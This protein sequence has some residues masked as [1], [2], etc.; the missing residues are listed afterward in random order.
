M[1]KILIIIISFNLFIFSLLLNADNN[2]LDSLLSG[3][4]KAFKENRIEEGLISLDTASQIAESQKNIKACL[5]IG[6]LYKDLPAELER[7][8]F[9][10]DILK[11]GYRFAAEQKKWH[12]LGKFAEAL[13]EL[14]EKDTA[15]EIYDIIFLQAGKNKDKDTFIALKKKYQKL[16]DSERVEFCDKMIK[17]LTITPPPGQPVPIQTVRDPKRQPPMQV[18]Q[19]QRQL[20]DQEIQQTLEYF[21]EKK[22]L[23]HDKKKKITPSNEY[24]P[25]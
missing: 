21:R 5:E 18:Q 17:A 22:Q 10:A 1:N 25:Y 3:A 8:V 23:E 24:S 19:M 14:G 6:L 12:I 11:K 13:G 16:G 15:V 4:S 9:A 2:E 7:N 20:S